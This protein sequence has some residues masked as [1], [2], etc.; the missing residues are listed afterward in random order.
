MNLISVSNFLK[1]K[2]ITTRYPVILA[3]GVGFRDDLLIVKYWGKIQHKLEK[4]GHKIYLS[5]QNAFS[6]HQI[7]AAKLAGKI[8]ELTCAGSSIDK[9]NIIAHSKGGLESRLAATFPETKGR[10]ASITTVATP[11]QG[12]P[13]AD[14]VMK[15][16]DS[17]NHLLAKAVNIYARFIGDEHPD[18]FAAGI[19]LTTEFMHEFNKTVKDQP[20]IA[21]RSYTGII[22]RWYPNP[23][24]AALHDFVRDIDG[25]ND[26]LVSLKSSQWGE[27]KG[28][29][30]P[31]RGGM[32]VSHLDMIGMNLL[33]GNLY[34][35]ADQF[36]LE[37]MNQ[38]SLEGF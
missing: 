2:S 35:K 15:K 21:Y 18:S 7:N 37:L 34:Y 6:S 23:I 33:T 8:I 11:H 10:I 31:A 27:F 29:L 16:I 19:E 36:F 14:L 1:K 4:S 26:G 32:G 24:I 9:V 3:H 5:G 17:K 13:V 28:I 12:S 22:D 38:L 30:K 25:E 20:E